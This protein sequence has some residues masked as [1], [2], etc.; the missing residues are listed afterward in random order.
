MM[1]RKEYMNQNSLVDDTYTLHRQYFGQFVNDQ[2]KEFILTRFSKSD[3]A[4]AL[5]QDKHFNSIPLKYWDELAGYGRNMTIDEWNRNQGRSAFT[6]LVDFTLLK[7]VGE[8]WCLST[9]T[10]IMKEAAKQIVEANTIE[11]YTVL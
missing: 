4:T 7:K 2:I 10:C 11:A 1:T 9:A 3:L 5:Y 6:R 8:G